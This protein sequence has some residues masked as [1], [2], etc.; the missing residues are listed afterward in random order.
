[1]VNIINDIVDE[2]AAFNENVKEEKV[3][4]GMKKANILRDSTCSLHK[5]SF[6]NDQFLF[7]HR[8]KIMQLCLYF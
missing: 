4:N 7:F 1:M 5:K 2:E 3:L 6:S 8:W